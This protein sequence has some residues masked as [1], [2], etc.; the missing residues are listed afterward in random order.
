MLT[1]TRLGL[2][3]ARSPAGYDIFARPPDDLKAHFELGRELASS[4]F[5]QARGTYTDRRRSCAPNNLS[6]PAAGLERSPSCQFAAR[7]GQPRPRHRADPDSIRATSRPPRTRQGR[8]ALGRPEAY[9]VV[10]Q[11][12]RR[13]SWRDNTQRPPNSPELGVQACTPTTLD[14]PVSPRASQRSARHQRPQ[15]WEILPS[16]NLRSAAERHRHPLRRVEAHIRRVCR[17]GEQFHSHRLS[18]GASLTECGHPQRKPYAA[19]V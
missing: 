14:R 12:G 1:D 15:Y 19:T 10:E 9:K 17:H 7:S 8:S 11:S 13:T 6:R 2:V 4:Q 5:D 18:L 3:H 16:L